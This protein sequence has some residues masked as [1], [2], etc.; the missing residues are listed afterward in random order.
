MANKLSKAKVFSNFW[1]AISERTSL[2]T[3][4]WLFHRICTEMVPPQ[5][6]K[7]TKALV[8][9]SSGRNLGQLR[10]L[11]QKTPQKIQQSSNH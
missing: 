8:A 2:S 7:K 10:Y 4:G 11:S 1:E 9:A 5:S 3:R 6:T